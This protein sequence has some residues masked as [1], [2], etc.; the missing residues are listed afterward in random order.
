[1]PMVAPFW[2]AIFLHLFR[3]KIVGG[4]WLRL[5]I[6]KC[7][8]YL[9]ETRTF[10][11]R[12]IWSWLPTVILALLPWGTSMLKIHPCFAWTCW[13]LAA[14]STVYAIWT[15]I[16]FANGIRIVIICSGIGALVPIATRSIHKHTELNF[17]FVNP[18]VF[19]VQGTGDWLLLVTGENTHESLFNIQ[20][21][22]QDMVTSRAIP[23]EPDPNKRLMM[24]RGGTIQKD[25]AE[26]GPWRKLQAITEIAMRQVLRSWIRISSLIINLG[27]CNAGC[28]NLLSSGSLWFRR[29]GPT[30]GALQTSNPDSCCAPDG[31][32]PRLSSSSS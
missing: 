30:R 15:T 14:C 25:Y 24:I 7:A 6:S 10:G 18:G 31:G 3:W 22:L 12:D 26:I 4:Y 9:H 19:L 27:L 29:D 16:K 2:R 23:K 21:I 1:M 32:P 11:D 28:L 17:C 8:R 13:T 20:M 5:L